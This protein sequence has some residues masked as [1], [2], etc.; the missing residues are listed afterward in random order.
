MTQPQLPSF[1]RILRFAALTLAVAI[2]GPVGCDS[3]DDVD[4]EAEAQAVADE[5][6]D[7]FLDVV[8]AEPEEELVGDRSRP[9][10]FTAKGDPQAFSFLP[11]HS[12]ET[13]GASQCGVNEAV[14]GFDCSGHYCDNVRI[15]CHGYGGSV[16]PAIDG[17]S[18]WFEVGPPPG[19]ASGFVKTSHVCNADQKMTG[20]DCRGSYCDDI[21]IECS[22]SPG[23]LTDPDRCILSAW[24]SE[25]NSGPFLA[26]VGTVIQGVQC[27]GTHCDNK[28]F[29]VCG[30]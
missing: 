5:I 9:L 26:P 23:F 13:P 6:P 20:I 2:V 24:F 27:Q 11:F 14:T 16:P 8:L 30:I 19:I 18:D 3:E 21:S 4:I 25:E 17:F 22:P 28:R 1:A 15:E 7:E 12:E 10:E 29:L